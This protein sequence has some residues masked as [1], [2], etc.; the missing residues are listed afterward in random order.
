MKIGAL[1][2]SYRVMP[3]KSRAIER[4]LARDVS[5]ARE[6]R[7]RSRSDCQRAEVRGESSKGSHHNTPPRKEHCSRSKSSSRS[8][9]KSSSPTDSPDN[10]PSWAKRLLEAHERNEERLHLLGKELKSWPST[11]R[12]CAKSPQ[13]EFK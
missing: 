13:F 9:S 5:P 8:K 11:E 2:R 12:S 4:L 1:I 7:K 6:S 10:T 3:F